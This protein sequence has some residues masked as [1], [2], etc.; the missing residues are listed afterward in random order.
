MD[1]DDH[2]F[3]TLVLGVRAIA[4]SAEKMS[5]EMLRIDKEVRRLIALRA[6]VRPG[7]PG[8]SLASPPS[9]PSPLMHAE[10]KAGVTSLELQRKPRGGMIVRVNERQPFHVAPQPA[11]LLEL[12]ATREADADG[13]TGWC[14]VEEIVR[15]LGLD[16]AK[17]R[18]A[19]TNVVNRLVTAFKRAGENPLLITRNHLG[20]VRFALRR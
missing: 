15:V 18:T 16:P 5:A 9:L 19:V 11:A 1:I 8:A 17:T 12:L 3:G 14:S 13:M 20:A 10:A 6:G 7:A 2:D 4:R